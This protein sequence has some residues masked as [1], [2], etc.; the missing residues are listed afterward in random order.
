MVQALIGASTP[1]YNV[2]PRDSTTNNN[3]DVG[4]GT[5]IIFIG[6]LVGICL[7]VGTCDGLVLEMD[8]GS[9]P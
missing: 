5:N 1:D 7:V 8:D 2:W 6:P 3:A 4:T 9:S